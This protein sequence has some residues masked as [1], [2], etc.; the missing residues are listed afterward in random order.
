[1]IIIGVINYA[2]EAYATDW[3]NV[4]DVKTDPVDFSKPKATLSLSKKTLC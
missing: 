3:N 2:N 4:E 1:M